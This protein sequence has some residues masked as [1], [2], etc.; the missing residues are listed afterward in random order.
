MNFSPVP[1]TVDAGG[2]GMLNLAPF[3]VRILE[4]PN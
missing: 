1:R 3:G 2:A 4:R